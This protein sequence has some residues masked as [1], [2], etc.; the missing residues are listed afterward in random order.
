MSTPSA[1]R[2]GV[3][4]YVYRPDRARCR[5]C[6][7]T[8]DCLSVPK[9]QGG[10]YRSAPWHGSGMLCVECILSMIPYASRYGWRGY[11][12]T[13]R[14]VGSSVRYHAFDLYVP[15]NEKEQASAARS[16]SFR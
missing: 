7:R 14:W 4:S 5:E 11:F 3:S 2:P 1:H 12:G 6:R 15:Y 13:G 8:R 9:L 10:N 16:A